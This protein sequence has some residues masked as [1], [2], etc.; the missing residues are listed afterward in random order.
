M[1]QAAFEAVVRQAIQDI[2]ETLRRAL[3]NVDI[4]I[5]DFPDP[6]YLLEIGMDGPLL[7]L[8][9]GI[10]LPQREI[11]AVDLPDKIT[12]FQGEFEVL[13]LNEAELIREIRI[14]VAHEIGHYFGLDDDELE[15]MGY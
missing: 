13:D 11:G 3:D 5:E 1:D 15:K 9:E 12:L 14:T 4:V 6:E 7:G 10:P 8:Y 2:P